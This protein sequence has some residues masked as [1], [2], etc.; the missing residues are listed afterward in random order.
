M[1]KPIVQLDM[2]ATIHSNGGIKKEETIDI[3]D[4][5]KIGNTNWTGNEYGPD[6]LINELEP[7][8]TNESI[9][10]I[11]ADLPFSNDQEPERHVTEESDSGMTHSEERT[12]CEKNT[13]P[14]ISFQM[15]SNDLPI[16]PEVNE[17]SKLIWPKTEQTPI[18][19]I[20]VTNGNVE[21]INK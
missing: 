16:Q 6:P 7:E 20:D 11:Y 21:F 4:L 1:E 5:N 18:I 2:T 3:L 10:G 15:S 19:E 14:I 9:T 13:T 8:D 12:D 17:M